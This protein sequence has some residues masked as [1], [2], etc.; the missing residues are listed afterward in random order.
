MTLV[1]TT[2][3]L[4]TIT[5][6]STTKAYIAI[7]PTTID[8]AGGVTSSNNANAGDDNNTTTSN[9]NGGGGGGDGG[10]TSTTIMNN[11]GWNSDY[12]IT[13]FTPNT[14]S[15]YGKLCST[16]DDDILR[17]IIVF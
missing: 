5:P 10:V 11:G 7:N 12:S 1:V 2:T 3:R 9:I 13:G 17:I 14:G 6:A 8:P 4:P 16:S 15:P